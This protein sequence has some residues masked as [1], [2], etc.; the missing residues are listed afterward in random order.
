MLGTLAGPPSYPRHAML[1]PL[2]VPSFYLGRP[3][4]A[5]SPTL[6]TAL[7]PPSL[8]SYPRH[9]LNV[10]AGPSASPL[11]PPPLLAPPGISC[12]WLLDP[13]GA[14]FLLTID[15]SAMLPGDTLK[16]SSAGAGGLAITLPNA[17]S[18]D[19][20]LFNSSLGVTK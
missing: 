7:H 6:H 4:W 12:T 2:S 14:P 3:C 9:L 18:T 16:L 15:Y 5:L 1:G 8:L 20:G 10:A 17:S 11:L 13:S 19:G